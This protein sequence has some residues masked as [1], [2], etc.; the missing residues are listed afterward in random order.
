VKGGGSVDIAST[1]LNRRLSE[2]VSSRFAADRFAIAGQAGFFRLV[3]LGLILFGVGN[4][5]GIGFYGYS[6][7]SRNSENLSTLSSTFSKERGTVSASVT[8]LGR[9]AQCELIRAN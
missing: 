3:G 5:L 7:I 1:D 2:A 8:V 4:A 9:L 6:F